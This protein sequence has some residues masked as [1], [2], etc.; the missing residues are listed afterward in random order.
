MAN[1]YTISDLAQEFDL[2]TRAIRF[3][4]RGFYVKQDYYNGINAAF[5]HT[6]KANL[7]P[8][9][10]DAI[11]SYGHANIIRQNV[12]EMCTELIDDEKAKAQKALEEKAK[13]ELNKVLPGGI[14]GLLGGKKK[15]DDKKN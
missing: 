7:L 11:V 4:E 8:D 14:G 1:T 15:T 9:R 2:T 10:F 5:V 13:G 3:Y 12:V 6:L